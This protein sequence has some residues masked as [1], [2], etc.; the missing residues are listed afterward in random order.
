M[1]TVWYGRL[2]RGFIP[3]WARSHLQQLASTVKQQA[4]V[5]WGVNCIYNCLLTVSVI[6]DRSVNHI[7]ENVNRLLG[8][9]LR[10]CVP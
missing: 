4:N 1:G 6:I 7:V 8:R 5:R 2:L 3:S 9:L 10:R